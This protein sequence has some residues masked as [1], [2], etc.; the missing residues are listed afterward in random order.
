MKPRSFTLFHGFL[1][2]PGAMTPL[3]RALRSEF[4]VPVR[5]AL[6][7]GHGLCPW[8]LELTSFDEGVRALRSRVFTRDADGDVVIGYSLGG[9]LALGLVALMPG[10]SCVIAV[11]AHAGFSS[12]ET[13]ERRRRAE[14]DDER[15]KHVLEKGML[16]FAEAWAREPIFSTQRDLPLHVQLG[17]AHTRESHTERG[18]AWTLTTLGTGRM[19]DLRGRLAE[20][21]TRV[22]LIAGALDTKF[23]EHH[24]SLDRQ[25]LPQVQCSTIAGCGHN[26]VLENPGGVLAAVRAA[27][28][29]E[30]FLNHSLSI[31]GA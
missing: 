2:L 23:V 29:S 12:A 27:L 3:A 9:R 1:G 28:T 22:E 26:P 18:I 20:S 15:A 21:G 17:Q 10:L 25:R 4:G 31:N 24:R 30:H 19:P 11:G 7:P 14:A 5:S 8:G 6:L 16:A 13:D